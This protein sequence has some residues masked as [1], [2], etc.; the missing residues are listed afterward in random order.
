MFF[1]YLNKYK[2]LTKL[3]ELDLIQAIC[4]AY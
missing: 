1:K 2:R 3:V 4:Q